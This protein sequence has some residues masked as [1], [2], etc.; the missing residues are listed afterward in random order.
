MLEAIVS[1][2]VMLN[3]FGLFFYLTPVKDHMKPKVFIDTFLKS[4]LMSTVIAIL[5]YF[6]GEYFF[7]NILKINFEAFRIFGGIIIFSLSFLYLI[8]GRRSIIVMK[9]NPGDQAAEI[10]LP[11]MVGLGSISLIVIT[12]RNMPGLPGF[13]AVISALL[14]HFFA[15]AG[16]LYARDKIKKTALKN[17]FEETITVMV[18]LNGFFIGTIC[19]NMIIKGIKSLL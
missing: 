18:R 15:A 4:S 13:I 17:Y 12:S 2:V 9:D 8:G 16:F 14:I 19:V 5:F 1:L 10:A 6:F 7:I 3:P 11:F